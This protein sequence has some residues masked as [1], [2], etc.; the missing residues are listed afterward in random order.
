MRQ[1]QKINNREL[2]AKEKEFYFF[3]RAAAPFRDSGASH[4]SPTSGGETSQLP[5]I[6]CSRS[7]PNPSPTQGSIYLEKAL[8]PAI[9]S[10][11]FYS[12]LSLSSTVPCCLSLPFCPPPVFSPPTPV[13]I[14]QTPKI[15]LCSSPRLDSGQKEN[16]RRA[17][18]ARSIL[19]SA[20]ILSLR[21]ESSDPGFR[22]NPF[23]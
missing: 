13:F 21:L 19:A 22:P 1:G 9:L 8:K 16:S 20:G 4:P 17:P 18:R 5:F 6:F 2:G 11:A 3:E 12:P 10:G 23:C 15:G 7:P 14:S